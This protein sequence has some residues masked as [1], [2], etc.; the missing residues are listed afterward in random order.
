MRLIT[1]PIS[2]YC[3]K[4]R[5]ALARLGLQYH[6][7]RHLQGFHYPRTF[8]FSRGPMVPVLLDGK[9]MV[10]DSTRILEHL[11]RLRAGRLGPVSRG[12]G[13][14]CPGERVGKSFR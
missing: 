8:W 6:E 10:S 3:E 9:L 2:H 14:T 7:E 12:T 4:A 5:W 1:I 13:A 11:D